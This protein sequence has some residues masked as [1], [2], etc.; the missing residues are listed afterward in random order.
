MNRGVMLGLAL[1]VCLVLT[2]AAAAAQYFPAN[3]YG[4]YGAGPMEPYGRPTPPLSPYLN[5]LGTGNPAV[6]YFLQVVPEFNRRVVLSQFDAAIRETQ[7]S[8]ASA[9]TGE[10][11]ALLR[12]LQI[13]E[14]LEGTGHPVRFADTSPYYNLRGTPGQPATGYRPL[15]S[16]A[17]PTR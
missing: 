4:P 9:G 2:S 13:S 7:R 12:A 1:L 5:L 17:R 10:V 3:P 16:F 14:P 15:P 8:A 6:N 11:E